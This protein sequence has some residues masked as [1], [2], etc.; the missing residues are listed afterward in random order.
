MTSEQPFHRFSLVYFVYFVSF[1]FKERN[2]FLGA[3]STFV[4]ADSSCGYD[5]RG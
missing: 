1:V 2:H 5:T 4:T 3:V